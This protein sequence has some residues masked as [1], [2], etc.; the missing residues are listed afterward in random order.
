MH[1]NKA[2]RIAGA[3]MLGT[4]V[5]LG[6]NAASAKINL[7]A[8]DKGDAVST[9]AQE[10]IT[11]TVAGEDG[12]MYYVVD[13][14]DF[15]LNVGGQVGVGGT[16]G[17]VL[18][19]EYVFDG[20]VFT[21]D[22]APVLRIGTPDSGATCDTANPGG[23]E[24]TM[25]GGG[26]KGE[27]RVSFI[28]T[29]ELGNVDGDTIACLELEDMGVSMGGGGVTM[30][31]SDN[32][33]LPATEM[34]SYSNAVRIASALKESPMKNNPKTTVS[35]G[36]LS[37][38][39]D[40][41]DTDAAND[42]M[43]MATVGSFMVSADI[44]LLNAGDGSMVEAADL[45]AVGD[46]AFDGDGV[47]DTVSSVHI[48]GDFSFASR[49]TLDDMADCSDDNADDLRMPE[50]D[51]VRDTTKLKPQTLAYVNENANLCITVLAADDDDAVQIPETA[52]YMVMVR[53][54]GGTEDAKHPTMGMARELGS[55]VRDGTTVRFPFLA[56]QGRYNQWIRIVNRGGEAKY[57][58]SFDAKDAD[59]GDDAEGTLPTGTTALS[60]RD[61]DVVTL[62]EG[63]GS[64]SGSLIIEAQPHMID[65]A[66]VLV[67]RDDSSTD[68][69][70]Y[71]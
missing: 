40:L 8:E 11:E 70:I 2:L 24:A 33:P 3:A 38:E 18:I 10:T 7:D 29:R 66:T 55:I 68:T 71:D 45:Y 6:T 63:V 30:S 9:F 69:V 15:E 51:M 26:K 34:K 28:F 32:L 4:A 64:T 48:A 17:S 53:Y 1:S 61:D 20:M 25:R 16:V 35:S 22:S 62:P 5:L 58:M 56:I 59:H 65:V 42:T 43:Q 54:A 31:V 52:P 13:G 27:D 37:F 44:E 21:A 50:V 39:G 23:T 41:T 67:N 46:T 19:L 47:E 12:T 57:V 49:V 60:L 36:F 14:G